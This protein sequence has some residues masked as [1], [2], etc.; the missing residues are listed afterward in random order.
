MKGECKKC[1]SFTVS[2]RNMADTPIYDEQGKRVQSY[3]GTHCELDSELHVKSTN[4]FYRAR[5]FSARNLC[6]EEQWTQSG[7]LCAG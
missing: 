6:S 7:N 1:P 4:Q 5:H 3:A 2:R